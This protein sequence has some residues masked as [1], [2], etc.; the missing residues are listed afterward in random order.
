MSS[1]SLQNHLVGSQL[2]LTAMPTN[3]KGFKAAIQSLCDF[4]VTHQ[5]SATLWLKLP[6]DDAWWTD[7]WQY[8]QQA[9]GCTIYS[10]GTQ[11]GSPPENMAAS[12]RPIPIEQDAD[13]KR[14]YLCMA[15]A[16]S[17]VV[18]LLAV[19]NPNAEDKRTLQLYCTVSGQAIAAIATGI[20]AVLEN[21]QPQPDNSAAAERQEAQ[22]NLLGDRLETSDRETTAQDH[23]NDDPAIAGQAA[24]SQWARLFPASVLLQ[25]TH[26]LDN[27][28]LTWQLQ[29]QETL[30]S[31]LSRQN[32]TGSDTL[33]V[34]SPSFLSQ[35]K[36]E[37]QSPLTTI[38]TAL[39]LLGSPTIKLSQRQLYLEMIATQCD[40]QKSL[41]TS[42]FDLLLEQTTP[43][44]P[45]E[46]LRLSDIVPG[47]VS[48]YQPLAE[49]RGV[50]LAHTIPPNL[51]EAMGIESALKEVL[52]HLIENGIAIA[53]KGGRVWVTAALFNS[54]T[55]SIKVQDSGSG[56]SRTD[57]A[58]LFEAFYRSGE[59]A[60]LG[61][62]LAK[63]LIEKMGGSIEVESQADRG[64]TLKI[65]L[66][67]SS[68]S[69][70]AAALPATTDSQTAT[71][72]PAASQSDK[73]AHSSVARQPTAI[74]NTAPTNRASA[75]A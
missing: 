30:R 36:Q 51:P 75:L 45:A 47:I 1:L 14:E 19:R 20:K 55:I 58:R 35:A 24:L 57:A 44:A 63:Q 25:A 6:K 37:L 62:T 11:T 61:L 67:I 13:L 22:D 16:D 32:K 69:A 8:G 68:A 64:T 52:I 10:L 70:T 2:A 31:E 72:Q 46:P 27:A 29:A 38:K 60:G 28:F 7:V 34:F 71:S 50:M 54:K 4:L 59:G 23:R 53:P 43:A 66:P 56:I 26:P 21:S 17:F 65:Q 48:T 41:I 40:R 9:V 39:T 12:L 73:T 3:P 74:G 15:V 42:V 33:D 49:E 18:S 5:V